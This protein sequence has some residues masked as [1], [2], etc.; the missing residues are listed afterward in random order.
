VGGVA[1]ASALRQEAKE[2]PGPKIA[3]LRAAAEGGHPQPSRRGSAVVGEEGRPSLP[4]EI[5]Q[6]VVVAVDV[7]HERAALPIIPNVRGLMLR[8]LL[9]AAAPKRQQRDDQP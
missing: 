8:R 3:E 1:L 6:A 7:T 2:G 9:V 4:I 5:S